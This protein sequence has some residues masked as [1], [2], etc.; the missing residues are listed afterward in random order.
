MGKK[1][2]VRL[3]AWSALMLYLLCDLIF[4]TG[5]LK[6][7][8]DKMH[9][10]HVKKMQLDQDR[11]IIARVFTVP[12]YLSQVDYG[13]DEYLWRNGRNRAELTAAERATLRIKVLDELIDHSILREKIA[14][15]DDTFPVSQ[16]EI[17][18]AIQRFTSRFST[19]Q[20]MADTLKGFG[21]KHKKELE[22]RIA[23]RL[24]Q[25][26]YIDSKIAPAIA[27]SVDEARAWY[28]DHRE[29]LTTPERIKARHIFLSKLN[30][31]EQ[32]A[33]AKLEQAKLKLTSTNFD[34]LAK[35]LSADPRTSQA[36]GDLQWMQRERLPNDFAEQAFA[37]PLDQPRII[38]T[39]IGW[40][41][42]VVTAKRS[43][44]LANFEQLKPEIIAALETSRRKD[45]IAQYRQNLRAQHYEKII[46]H[47]E[48]IESPWT[49]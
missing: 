1:F 39:K 21:F 13:V 36:G 5:P 33:L 19:P 24:Q 48:L 12:I 31:N 45:A 8:V 14:L 32:Q 49:H 11:D 15:N 46:V 25:N 47:S 37:L 6:K 44:E 3:I 10:S 17:T 35:K 30:H 41:L 43:A 22:F 2:V 28:S 20:Q 4:F 26:K 27:V 40:H 34:E 38:E 9:N 18:S 23:A 42:I 7:Q 29:E 16:A